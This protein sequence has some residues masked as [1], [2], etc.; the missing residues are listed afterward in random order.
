MIIAILFSTVPSTRCKLQTIRRR[1]RKPAVLRR[2][3]A[4]CRAVSFAAFLFFS[5]LS[6]LRL[7]LFLTLPT[8][9]VRP[10]SYLRYSHFWL[11]LPY[12]RARRVAFHP[13]RSL[14]SRRLL[15]DRI[16][17]RS[18]TRLASPR[19]ASQISNHGSVPQTDCRSMPP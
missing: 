12:S 5:I 7:P 19:L 17:P 15:H 10:L 16:N 2:R 3:P 1:R 8:G 6:C 9:V 14:P 4:R 18:E 13:I 11:R